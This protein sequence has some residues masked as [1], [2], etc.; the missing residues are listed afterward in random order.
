MA[1]KKA[2][3]ESPI[4]LDAALAG[5]ITDAKVKF[6][7]EKVFTGKE[8]E[9]RLV[10]IWLPSLCLRYLYQTN[11]QPLG[12]AEQITGIQESCKSAFLYEKYRWIRC[13]G[14]KSYHIENESKDSDALRMSI[15]NY[16]YSSVDPFISGSQDEWQ[17]YLTYLTQDNTVKAA[18]LGTRENPGPG[19]TV[20]IGMG[21]D[22]LTAK[23]S[24]E[25]QDK[26]EAQGC[27]DRVHPVDALKISIY[28][29]FF[30]QRM[31]GWPF[32]LGCINHLKPTKN[33]MGA[34]DYHTPGGYSIKFQETFETRLARIADVDSGDNG[35]LIKF[36]TQKNSLGPGR[37]TI[38]AMFRW[39]F[40]KET[41]RQHSYWDWDHATID[42]LDKQLKEGALRK[43][44]MNVVDLRTK[45]AGG[46][47]VWS[48]TL[49]IPESEAVTYSEAGRILESKPEIIRELHRVLG[50]REYTVFKPGID[51]SQ[52]LKDAVVAVERAEGYTAEYREG[53]EVV[54]DTIL[55]ESPGSDE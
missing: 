4:S 40:N 46:K 19:K 28:L 38:N 55:E 21:V 54:D 8:S 44:C 50:I 7:D 6:G 16:D 34:I 20:P 32:W 13:N 26:I 25:I 51:Y 22:S 11:I 43:A 24:K 14:G 2:L 10:G 15:M 37:K 53:E 30:P 35:V 47:R 31:A 45:S 36:V 1:K 42:L 27:A 52:Q 12:R 39:Y 33:A 49:D 17:Q 23:A 41:G 3:Q 29:K 5:I 48:K 18:L 9:A